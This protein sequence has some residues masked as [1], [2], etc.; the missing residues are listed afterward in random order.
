MTATTDKIFG[1]FMGVYYTPPG[2]QP[3]PSAIWPS[4]GTYSTTDDMFVW[5]VPAWVPGM[6]FQIQADGTVAQA[7]LGSQFN[8]SNFAAGSTQVGLSNCTA[9]FA[10]V[11]GASQ[12]QL[13]LEEFY[14]GV[15]S[16]IGDAY[17]DLI[18]G[19]SYPQ[20][21]GGFQTSIG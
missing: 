18:V 7:L 20:I 14:P 3:T 1:V 17:T 2:G 16:A 9:A 4:G 19:V 5:V 11:A 12:G 15:S 8:L 21:V 10:G 6:R 13:V